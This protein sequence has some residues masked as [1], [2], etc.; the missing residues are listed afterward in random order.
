MISGSGEKVTDLADAGVVMVMVQLLA[1]LIALDD[2]AD[3]CPFNAALDIRDGVHFRPA[4]QD[5]VEL[6]KN[7]LPVGAELIER[8]CQHIPGGAHAAVQ[9]QCFHTAAFP[10]SRWLIM[11]AI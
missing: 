8:T 5:P 2:D 10:Q 7:T 9:I 3:V 11:L 1:L 6:L 4:G